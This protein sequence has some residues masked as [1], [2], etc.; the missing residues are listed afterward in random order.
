MS[1]NLSSDA[2]VIGAVRVNLVHIVS[3]LITR[4]HL[5]FISFNN[6]MLTIFIIHRLFTFTGCAV[7]CP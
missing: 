7:L 4:A 1:Q 5:H 3:G 2:V 6:N